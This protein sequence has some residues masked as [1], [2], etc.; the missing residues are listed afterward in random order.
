MKTKLFFITSLFLMAL[1]SEKNFGQ[2]HLSIETVNAFSLNNNKLGVDTLQKVAVYLP[3]DYTNSNKNYP[4]VY[5]LPGFTSP[6][7]EFLFGEYNG[8]ELQEDVD[9]LIERQLIN[10]MII[11]LVDG[12]TF[13]GGSFYVN[14]SIN[15]NWEDYIA[16]DIVQY[17]DRKYKTIP[18]P[19][20]RAIA[21]NSMGGF[22]ALHIAMKHPD[23]FGMVYS[24][25]PGLFD[26]N[27]ILNSRFL[28]SYQN[29]SEIQQVISEFFNE[30]EKNEIERYKYL[31][32][33]LR[34]GPYDGYL[35][36]FL[37][38]YGSAF[39]PDTS[40]ETPPFFYLPDTSVTETNINE[41]Q[42]KC[43]INGFGGWEEKIK[44]HHSNL[45]KLNIILDCGLNDGW[46]TDGTKYVSNL[47]EQNQIKVKTLWFDGG[48]TDRLHIRLKEHMLPSISKFFETQT[49]N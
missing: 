27:G 14:S 46:I 32:A 41:K 24:L 22:G 13:L 25:S 11:V 28:T 18:S 35:K 33:N 12:N 15:G 44:E 29:I 48:H 43:W 47:L 8:F 37:L 5:Y 38:A 36:G 23:V 7:N 2:S 4:V 42:F 10:E 49:N 16:Y 40:L 20:S 1:T 26:A 6:I 21:G 31:T 3:P 39:C 17:I 9:F 45:K 30:P 34:Y 19:N